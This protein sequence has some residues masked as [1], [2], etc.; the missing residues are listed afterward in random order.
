MYDFPKLHAVFLEMQNNAKPR[1]KYD[2]ENVHV[3]HLKKTE[4]SFSGFWFNSMTT[5]L[6]G[7]L[8]SL[9]LF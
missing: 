6:C 1:C 8:N 7:K 9:I 5:N 2:G 4:I 3:N